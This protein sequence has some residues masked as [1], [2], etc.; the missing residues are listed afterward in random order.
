MRRYSHLALPVTMAMLLFA[1]LPA[2]AQ[3]PRPLDDE[4]LEDLRSEPLDEVVAFLRSTALIQS[5][6]MSIR[7]AAA[8]AS[9][10]KRCRVPGRRSETRWPSVG[11]NGVVLRSDCARQGSV[12]RHASLGSRRPRGCPDTVSWF[13]KNASRFWVRSCI[14]WV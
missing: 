8:S 1:S 7:S 5:I 10:R 11:A 13:L 2:A 4:L 6:A 3:P 12:G 9:D 14:L